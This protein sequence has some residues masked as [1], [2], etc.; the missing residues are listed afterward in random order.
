VSQFLI[1]TLAALVVVVILMVQASRV[2]THS[3]RRR[4]FGLGAAAFVMFAIGNGLSAF[5]LGG[6]ANMV[7]SMIGAMLIGI[8]LLTLTRAYQGGEMND[9]MRRAREMVA[10]ERIRTQERLRRKHEEER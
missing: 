5:G 9:K 6:Q 1:R 8:S 7:T 4:A 2:P 3:S 10:E